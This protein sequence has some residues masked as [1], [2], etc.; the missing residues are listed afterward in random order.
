MLVPKRNRK[1][2]GPGIVKDNS[3]VFQHVKLNDSGTYD[4]ETFD[5]GGETI[6]SE[7]IIVCVYAKVP[8]PKVDF[9]CHDK[10]MELTC[11]IDD[12]KELSFTWQSNG[13]ELNKSRIFLTNIKPDKSMYTCTAA[14][15]VHSNKSDPVTPS[16]S[17]QRTLLGFELWTMVGILASGGALVL[18]LIIVMVTVGCRSCKRKKKHQSDEEEY[19]L[20]YLNISQPPQKSKQTA[21]GQPAPPEPVD[22]GSSQN[23]VQDPC[24]TPPQ[25]RNQQRARPPP[26]PIDE[27]EEQ[28]PPLPQPRKKAQAKKRE[29]PL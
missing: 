11:E 14:N 4:V 1:Q 2:D 24:Q 25:T 26:P 22:N 12:D 23:T 27:D 21:R 17:N 8:K 20:N 3:L 16:C 6:I 10:K 19:R 18:I 29:D 7:K 9:K 28:P 5:K 13:K 15:P